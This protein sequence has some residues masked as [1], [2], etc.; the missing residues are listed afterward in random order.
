MTCYLVKF[1]IGM[2]MR[3]CQTLF[4]ADRCDIVSQVCMLITGTYIVCINNLLHC[5]M[6]K[7]L[8]TSYN[9][10]PVEL[11]CVK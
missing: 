10:I 2:Y 4:F 7:I 9:K 6:I 11:V 8:F 3:N 1:K 5:D